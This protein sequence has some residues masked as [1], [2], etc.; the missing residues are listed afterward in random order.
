LL[1][2]ALTIVLDCTAV[3]SMRAQISLLQRVEQGSEVSA[4][5]AAA[6]D[7]RV[8]LIEG[9]R[10]LAVLA[11]AA[12]FITWMYK[13]YRNLP[14]FGARLLEYSPGWAIGAFLTP[15]L[16][17]IRPYSVVT[18]IWKASVPGTDGTE[19]IQQKTPVMIRLWWGFWLASNF[20]SGFII[21]L[22]SSG[23]GDVGVLLLRSYFTLVA[24]LLAILAAAAAIAVVHSV[25]QRQIRT[26]QQLSSPP[27]LPLDLGEAA[28]DPA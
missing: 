12:T 26:G 10:S 17:L 24:D 21:Y 25:N 2:L 15:V 28:A 20:V 9:L 11:I 5:D 27:L 6:N 13:A 16:N 14:G 3:F 19:W 18:E 7:S 22:L 23:R 1:L 4:E 8:T